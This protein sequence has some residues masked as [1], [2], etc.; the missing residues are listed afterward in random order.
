MR[1]LAAPASRVSLLLD[2]MYPQSIAQQ[3]RTRGFDVVSIHE[4]P[5]RALEGMPDADVFAAAATHERVLVTENVA[6][7][8]LLLAKAAS[9]G[10][11]HPDITYTTNGRFPRGAIG[12]A[13]AAASTATITL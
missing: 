8:Q 5:F 11:P 2:E 3:L 10:K 7:F 12:T 13:S 1:S 6:D 4:P 9:R